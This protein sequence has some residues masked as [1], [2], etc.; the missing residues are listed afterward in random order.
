MANSCELAMQKLKDAA[1]SWSDGDKSHLVSSK[2]ERIG[3]AA[4]SGYVGSVVTPTRAVAGNA[5]WAAFLNLARE[6]LAV[7]IDV[8]RSTGQSAMTGF[9]VPTSEFRTL[10]SALDA[11]GMTAFY[12]GFGKGTKPITEAWAVARSADNSPVSTFVQELRQ[13]LAARP[14]VP[15]S[16]VEYKRTVYGTKAMQTFTDGAFAILEAADRPWWMAA[17]DTEMYR[18]AKLKGI[19]E[20]LKGD[21]LKKRSAEHMANPSDEMKLRANEAANYATFKDRNPLSHVATAGKM[22]IKR[23]A[24]KGVDPTADKETQAAQRG[25]QRLW[26]LADLVAETKLPFTGVP[27]SVAGKMVSVSPFGIFNPD[28][29]SGSNLK[30]ARGLANAGAG[31]GMVIVGMIAADKGLLTGGTPRDASERAQWTEAGIQPFSINIDALIDGGRPAKKG[32]TWVGLRILG[33]AASSLF[34][35]Y[36][37]RQAEKDEPHSPPTNIIQD[38]LPSPKAFGKGVGSQVE[39]LTQQTY[40]QSIGEMWEAT[41]GEGNVVARLGASS[42]PAP[43]LIGQVSRTVDPYVREQKGFVQGAKARI[44]LGHTNPRKLGPTGALP[45]K[46]AIER[47]GAGASPFPFRTSRD[48]ET[49]QEIRRLNVPFG[50]PGRNISMGKG[51]PQK[52]LTHADYEQFVTAIGRPTMDAI[53]EWMAD[54]D[55]QQL[56]DDTKRDVL[57]KV[58]SQ[59]RSGGRNAL[60]S[61]LS[62]Q[63]A[64]P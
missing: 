38:Y 11:D 3:T 1:H 42:I 48:T 60:K 26:K 5:T 49:L 46:T 31:S 63:E 30:M 29:Y 8:V 61:R 55:F 50:M 39:F 4:R 24:D 7:G 44:G 57:G 9:K 35:G 51:Q 33:P 6:P 13:R 15:N 18:L 53:E 2:I 62:A 47:V 27:S 52:R 23:K 54:P 21:A 34:M 25:A 17:F 64:T 43:A 37:M 28:L 41:K 14:G 20:G 58:V 59:I 36:S 10:A 19:K 16:T 32:D 40:L 22:N 45:R 56:D 12:R